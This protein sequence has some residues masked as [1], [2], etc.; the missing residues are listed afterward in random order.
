MCPESG[1]LE[2]A[3][4]LW[5][6]VTCHSNPRPLTVLGTVTCSGEGRPARENAVETCCPCEAN[7]VFTE[8]TEIHSQT[9]VGASPG[10]IGASLALPAQLHSLQPQLLCGSPLHVIITMHPLWPVLHSCVPRV[11]YGL[12]TTDTSE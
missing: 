3:V 8:C 6:R 4:E 12:V 5:K 1:S 10:R 7:T 2:V 9:Q 11:L